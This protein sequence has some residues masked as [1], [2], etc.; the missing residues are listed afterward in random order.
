MRY[1]GRNLVTPGAHEGA[2]Y[3]RW[4]N[5]NVEVFESGKCSLNAALMNTGKHFTLYK[6]VRQV[7]AADAGISG[8]LGRLIKRRQGLKSTLMASLRPSF[9]TLHGSL[10]LRTHSRIHL[11]GN[12]FRHF[13]ASP[14]RQNIWLARTVQAGKY[15]GYLALSSVV[16]VTLLIA[17]LFG[18]DALTYTDKH[19]DRVPVGPLALHPNTGGPKN[20]PVLSSYIND[21][22]T[23]YEFAHS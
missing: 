20:L 1:G 23:F 9:R 15:T 18:H 12:Q 2:G 17:G 5:E 3:Q 10:N 21:D 16:G 22:G 6:R 13:T 19:V 8:P 14:G 7:N 11:R 4:A